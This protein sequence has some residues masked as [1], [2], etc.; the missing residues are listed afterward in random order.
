MTG[1][2]V[3]GS[4][5]WSPPAPGLSA[6]Q[7]GPPS[8]P[9]RPRAGGTWAG[10]GRTRRRWGAGRSPTGHGGRSSGAGETPWEGVP[11]RMT[12]PAGRVVPA[13]E[14][15][16]WDVAL[17]ASEQLL[18]CV[19]SVPALCARVGGW[20]GARACVRMCMGARAL[21]AVHGYLGVGAQQPTSSLRKKIYE[22]EG[23][24]GP[25][26][27]YQATCTGGSRAMGTTAM[28]TSHVH[29]LRHKADDVGHG[30]LHLGGGRPLHLRAVQGGG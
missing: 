7:C 13:E 4:R 10:C 29:A 27:A 21:G 1:W 20:V 15:D 28:S 8:P 14:V 19:Q 2:W 11:V 5:G 25:D 16:R 18:F 3:R 6:C 24:S 26:K 23:S 9:R 22:C 12:V 17:L 30:E